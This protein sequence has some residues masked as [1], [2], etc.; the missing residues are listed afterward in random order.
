MVASYEFSFSTIS[1]ENVRQKKWKEVCF[2]Y[3]I[4]HLSQSILMLLITW[5]NSKITLRERSSA[6]CKNLLQ[7]G[8]T[9]GC[10]VAFQNSKLNKLT[11]LKKQT[12]FGCHGC[13][14]CAS[15]IARKFFFPFF[16]KRTYLIF[17]KTSL[18]YKLLS[19][20]KKLSLIYYWKLLPVAIKG[21]WF[22][23]TFCLQTQRCTSAFVSSCNGK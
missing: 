6:K 3:A 16:Q 18:R 12:S 1:P 9:F 17:A 7:I 15:E 2:H 21:P 11:F 8:V 23:A 5:Y 4:F 19:L 13:C 14:A 10:S 22:L 20:K